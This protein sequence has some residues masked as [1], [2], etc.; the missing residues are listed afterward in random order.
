MS[1][2]ISSHLQTKHTPPYQNS[3]QS[4]DSTEKF[5]YNMC[6]RLS[7]YTAMFNKSERRSITLVYLLLVLLGR[8][9]VDD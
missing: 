9:A 5:V 1:I 3:F 6:G 8:F 2:V 4:V 7:L